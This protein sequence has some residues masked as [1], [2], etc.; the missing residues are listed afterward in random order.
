MRQLHV[1]VLLGLLAA[2][3]AIAADKPDPTI[4]RQLDSLGIKYTVDDDNDFKITMEVDDGRRTQ[5]VFVRSNVEN[6]GSHHVREIWSPG[7]KASGDQFPANVANRLLEHSNEVKLGSWVKQKS[8]AIF[9]VKISTDAS[10]EQLND[11]L[12]AAVR[13]ADEVEQEFTGSKDEL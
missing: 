11:A 9:V 1:A 2:G 10:A 13:S 5:L 8:Y 7:Y 3:S 12:K 4:K 6:Y